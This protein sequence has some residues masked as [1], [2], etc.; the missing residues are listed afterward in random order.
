MADQNNTQEV[1]PEPKKC[2]CGQTKDPNGNCDGTHTT[3]TPKS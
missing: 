3:L 2:G 1:K